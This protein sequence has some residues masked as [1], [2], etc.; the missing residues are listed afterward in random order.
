MILKKKLKR[1][2]KIWI[3]K[4]VSKEDLKTGDI[5][6]CKGKG[7][8]SSIIKFCTKSDITH[9][10]L[11]VEAWGQPMIIDAQSNGISPKLFDSW[12]KKYN[13]DYFVL[14]FEDL[15]NKK[16]KEIALKSYEKSGITKYPYFNLIYRFVVHYFTG[17][18][19]KDSKGM[20]CSE[21]VGWVYN[22]KDSD[23]MT[24]VDLY[25]Y[26]KNLK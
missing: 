15:G 4:K 3:H 16:K 10:A 18:W 21:Y 23:K 26:F 24:P 2:R 13:Y 25:N 11:F 9:V 1:L 12:E 7:I 17:E 19:V 6:F 14:R 20:F 5:L 22:I 8:I